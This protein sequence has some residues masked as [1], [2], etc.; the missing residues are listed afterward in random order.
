MT[1]HMGTGQEQKHAVAEFFSGSDGWQGKYYDS[2]D[3]FG[4]ML[5]RREMYAL[6]LVR[7]HMPERTGNVLDVGCGSGVYLAPLA[8]MGFNVK[9]IDLSPGMLDA[10]RE[11]I[12][13]T[14]GHLP[15][16]LSPG[17]IENIPFGSSSFR[18]VLCIGV[19]GYLTSD[20]KGL[21]ELHRVIEPGG[22]LFISVRNGYTPI[23][24]MMMILRGIRSRLTGREAKGLRRDG[25]SGVVSSAWTEEDRGYQNKAY[26][27]KKFE[28]TLRERGFERLDALTFGFPMKPMRKLRVIP[29]GV[30]RALEFVVERFTQRL[31]W[32]RLTRMGWGYVGVFRKA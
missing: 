19:L 31:P 24:T 27:L 18:A 20:E 6:Q 8:E 3:S 23:N 15:I 10:C 9:G 21:A 2:N 22:L 16:E 12:S 17:D 28:S 32:S 29:A 25:K 26:D 13:R 5:Q 1:E 30:W 11:R 14:H 4:Q 7:R